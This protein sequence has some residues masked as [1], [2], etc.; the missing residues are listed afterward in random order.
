MKTKYYLTALLLL[1]L[2]G[3][4]ACS[5][6]QE[7]VQSAEVQQEEMMSEQ[8]EE[9][10]SS[11]MEESM[12]TSRYVEY[13]KD[14]YEQAA[15]KRRVLFFYA[16]WCPLCRPAD[17]SFQENMQSIPE[18]VVLF[19]VNYN[20]PDTDQDE[21]DLANIYSVTYQHTFVQVDAQGNGVHKWSGGE[22]NELLA[23]LKPS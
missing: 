5:T 9:G 20:D 2:I 16:S 3:I 15:D 14:A 12:P 8:K 10:S 22:I 13:S 18:D 4:S 11:S 19:R 1:T 21:T 7:S 6:P 17:A 23:N